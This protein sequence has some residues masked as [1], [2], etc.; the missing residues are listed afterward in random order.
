[1]INLDDLLL[2]SVT[3][4]IESMKKVTSVWLSLFTGHKKI[5]WVSK[6]TRCN[7]STFYYGNPYLLSMSCP[8]YLRNRQYFFQP[9]LYKPRF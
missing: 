8:P 5:L 3:K 1:M 9:T 2:G 7:L 4:L 6:K